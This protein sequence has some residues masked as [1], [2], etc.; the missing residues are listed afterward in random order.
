MSWKTVAVLVLLVAGLGGFFYYDTYWL[1]P[2]REKK[3]T[4]K[5]RL[6]DVEPKDVESL[7]LKRKGETVRLKRTDSG[8]ELLE[9]VKSARRPRR[10][11]RHRH[12]PRHR[13]R[14]PRGGGERPRKLDEFGLGAARVEVTLEVKGRAPL[15]LLVGGKSPTGAW[16]FGKES[17]SRRWSRC[18][19]SLARDLAKPVAELRDRTVLAFDRKSVSQVDPWQLAGEAISLESAEAGKWRIDQAA[20]AARRPRR[21]WPTSSRS[22]T[23]PR[24]RTS[25]TTRPSR[26]RPTASIDP[27]TVTLWVGKDKE[28][29]VAHAPLRARGQGQEGRLRD[30]GGRAGRHARSARSSGPRCPKTVGALRDKVVLAYQY[31]KVTRVELDGRRAAPSSLERDGIGWKITA[32]GASQGRH[33][34]RQRRAVEDPR[35]PGHRL[36]RR[37]GGGH[38]ALPARGPS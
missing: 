3:E 25:W 4:V 5:G 27:T 9:P 35:P 6:W 26:W 20:R 29:A 38:P 19:R 11:G 7:T 36:P 22:S 10:R 23:R 34:R 15:A 13:A 8:W 21:A 31:D 17:A 37:G 1:E 14:G 28:R 16:V 2:A 30:A 18:P 12:Q 24:P 33:R 32:P